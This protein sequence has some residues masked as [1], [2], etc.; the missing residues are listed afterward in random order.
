MTISANRW[1]LTVMSGFVHLHVHSEYSLLDGAARI[2]DIIS[3]AKALGQTAIAITDHGAM[4]GVVDFYNA[5][6]K[7]GI[8]PILG[9][10]AYIAADLHEKSAKN[11][12]YAHLLLLAKNQT[13]Y[14][15]LMELCSIGFIDGYYYKPR[16]DY[17][18][19][20][21]YAEG[22]ICTSACIA[23]D[24]PQMLMTGKQKEAEALALRLKELFGEDFYIEVQDHGLREE[25]LVNPLLIALANDLDIPL[26]V[27]ND[28]HYVEKED[29]RAQ[30][31]M[32]CLQMGRTLADGGGLFQTDEFYI[33]SEE[34][35]R[36]LFGYLP[37]ALENTV[38]IAEKCNV[39]IEQGVLHMPTF[40]VP[41]GYTDRQYLEKLVREGM[42]KRYGDAYIQHEERMRYELDTINNMGFTD[43]FLIV[44]DYVN[45]AKQE[46]IMVGP[47]RGSAAG[48]IVAY[49]LGITDIDP[50]EYNLLF[51]RFLNPERVSMPDIDIDF[52]IERRQEVIEYVSRKYG[53][54][55][56]AQLI[57][58]GT[59][60][61]KQVV[62]D[63][64]R[65]M[66]INVQEADR[67]AKMIPFA[68][69]MTIAQALEESPSLRNEYDN[70]EKIREWLDMAM[71][72]EGMPRQSST[73]AAAVVISADP[74]TK[75]SPLVLNKKDESITTQYNMH[76]IEALGLLKMD[77]L[78][79][80][81]LTVIRDT[82]ELVRKNRNIRLDMDHIDFEDKAVYELI[83]S[84]ETDGIFQLE[85]DGMRS[86]MT[87]MRPES[88]GDIMV[89][90]ALF[91]PGP[92]AKIPEYI[93]CKNDPAKVKYDHPMLE[94]ILK[95]TYG[96]MVY[97]E[98]VMEIVRDMAGYSL[99]RSDEVRRAMAKKKKDV[100]EK[101][102]QIFV[103]GG[104]G[105]EGAVKRGVPEKVAQSVYDQMMD[106][107]Q[108]AF[109]K[110]HACA[111]AF[112]TYQTAY[113]KCHYTA[114][115]MTALINSFISTA[116]K[117]AHYMRY[118][119][120][121]GIEILPPSINY[122]EKYF[123]VQNGAIRF[124]LAALSNVGDS[125]ETVFEE[126]RKSGKYLDFADFVK[127]NVAN[128]NKTQIES[129]ILSGAF[130][131]T[132]AKRS[133]LM[134]VYDR[135]LKNAQSDAK[136][137]QSG[138]MSLFALAGEEALPPI[139][140]PDIPEYDDKLKLALEKQKVGMYLSGHPL[141]QY[142]DQLAQEAW[143]IAKI[144]ARAENPETVHTM[145]SATVELVGV[146]SQ[147]KAR[148]T[149]R[150]RQMMANASFED[151]TGSIGVLI[152]P[153][154]YEQYRA[155]IK[156]D[157]ICRIRAK[158]S[159]GDETELLL[160][161]VYPYTGP[162][163][164]PSGSYR[165]TAVPKREVPTAVATSQM[166]KE[167]RLTLADEDI[168]KIRAIKAALEGCYENWG[169]AV[170]VYVQSTG[171]HYTLRAVK[172][173]EILHEKLEN[174]LGK[175]NIE[176]IL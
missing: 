98:Q 143:N 124:G 126:R 80:R 16:I 85:S 176:A 112:V 3:K 26:I 92:M 77:F 144:I 99:A 89:G 57:T 175:E 61:A 94:K 111:Y 115:F 66:G 91:R 36:A 156:P 136:R 90:I 47:G 110:S 134:E 113:L 32:M 173:T 120:Q 10:E 78:G 11:R 150:S 31:I 56:V 38:R 167:L 60:G 2:G 62:R 135:I 71:K 100:M 34:E 83:S 87:R 74:V 46:H 138:M 109:N 154:A 123:D 129:L 140:L 172:Y 82:V 127:R 35:M 121:C 30:D 54:D 13:G 125:I 161:A 84:G 174:I 148:T 1:E 58:F 45:F 28:V 162:V 101:E 20:A 169:A 19:L 39:E 43:Y 69:K 93:E 153:A 146:F 65:V 122:S 141:Q 149:R 55:H 147:I 41:A 59:L 67:V 130:D 137:S 133:Q 68:V 132:G 102:R 25:K 118:V 104:E 9:F 164:M 5:A 70:D 76:N 159:V 103:Y 6:K 157:E 40:E 163:K 48:S 23:G 86:L 114:E 50:I 152:F 155:D 63:V 117:V 52:C 106:F 168:Q 7:Q 75:Y 95:D 128:L 14:K 139:R 22:V 81:T 12:E 105:I 151:L 79:L 33:K 108:Y 119:K 131:E 166:V 107:A 51:E 160:E 72:I 49:A 158:V 97:Q 171:K 4:Y 142:A 96:C 17:Q 145:E 42:H 53:K 165:K 170:K 44:W 24:I 21:K 64:A 88:L 18:T 27:T 15:N 37:E 116:D 73:H 8:K 29:A